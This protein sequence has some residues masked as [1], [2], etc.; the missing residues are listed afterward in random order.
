MYLVDTNVLSELRKQRKADRGVRRFFER[1]AE[2][3]DPLYLSVITIGELRRG[4]ELIRHRGDGT[5]AARLEAWLDVILEEYEEHI[6]GLDADTAQLWGKLR[7]PH[8]EHPLDKQIAATAL[9]YGLT[10]VTRNDRDYAQTGV[11]VLNPFG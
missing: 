4:I 5:Q 2:N 9:I 11:E 6:L 7:V 8:P 10:V 3:S 1:A